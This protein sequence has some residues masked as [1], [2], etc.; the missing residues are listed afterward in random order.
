M[1]GGQSAGLVR[2]NDAAA[3]QG[4]NG[5]KTSHDGVLSSH[6]AGSKRKAGGDDNRKTLRDGRNTKGNGNLEVVDGTLGPV[7]MA[8][9]GKVGDVDEPDENADDSDN[10]GELVAEIVELLLQGG[11]LGNLR[12]DALV[13][14]ADSGVG[15]SQDN[16]GFGVTSDDSGA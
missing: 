2:A 16:D 11:R 10:L 14:V 7:S 15:T 8:G 5:G 1:V 13:N 6:L 12:G 4:L 9:V 3:T